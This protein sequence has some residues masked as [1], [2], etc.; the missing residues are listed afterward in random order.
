MVSCINRNLNGDTMKNFTFNPEDLAIG[1]EVNQQTTFSRE[2]LEVG[3]LV[4]EGGEASP[5]EDD[6]FIQRAS[7]SVAPVYQR[8]IEKSGELFDYYTQGTNPSNTKLTRKEKLNFLNLTESD[9][10]ETPDK[11]LDKLLFQRRIKDAAGQ[12]PNFVSKADAKA[13]EQLFNNPEAVKTLNNN[14][15]A[16]ASK[17]TSLSKFYD[18]QKATVNRMMIHSNIL[19]SPEYK[20]NF[21]QWALEF[22]I[23]DSAVRANTINTPATQAYD[24][25]WDQYINDQINTW[26]LIKGTISDPLGSAEGALADAANSV[27]SIGASIAGRVAGA[28]AGGLTGSVAG[29]VGAAV[30]AAK[31]GIIGGFIGSA[32]AAVD[33]YIMEEMNNYRDENGNINWDGVRADFDKLV[34][35]W[36]I[37]ATQQ[38]ITIGAIE[39]WLVPGVGGKIA[40]SLPA[41]VAK[42]IS[43][44]QSTKAGK[45]ASTVVAKG[46]EEAIGEGAG[47]TVA[48]SITD[49]QN[50]RLDKNTLKANARGGLREAVA[51][52]LVGGA[53]GGVSVIT[54]P[55]I[56][57]AADTT[58]T[59]TSKFKK[60][61]VIE[62]TKEDTFEAEYEVKTSEGVVEQTDIMESDIDNASAL[63]GLTDAEKIK[64]YDD[65]NAM[66]A[67]IELEDGNVIVVPAE[68]STVTVNGADLETLL[69]PDVQT[70][71]DTVDP[72]KKDIIQNAI[73]NGEDFELTYGEWVV[74]SSKLKDAHPTIA[75]LWKDPESGLY[76]YEAEEV[77]SDAFEAIQAHVDANLQ[78]AVDLP[79]LTPEVADIQAMP[80]QTSVVTKVYP[81]AN[82]NEVV[83]ELA[84]GTTHT[85]ELYSNT[86]AVEV[87]A[88]MDDLTKQFKNALSRSGRTSQEV[89]AAS[90]E[91][92][93]IITRV[94]IKR[95]AALN[96]PLSDLKRSI[97]F[98]S[99]ASSSSAYIS[100]DFN[101]PDTLTYGVGRSAQRVSTVIHEFAHAI[102]NFMIIDAPKLQYALLNGTLSKEGQE[103]LDTIN[104]TSRLLGISDISA[105][106]DHSRM[107]LIDPATGKPTRTNQAGRPLTKFTYLHEKLANTMEVFLKKGELDTENM[108]VDVAKTL[109]YWRDLIPE[110]IVNLLES[111]SKEK[112]WTYSAE[113]HQAIDP[114]AE[115]AEVFHGMYAVNQAIETQAVPLFNFRMF[116]IEL[117][118]SKG[119]EL[120]SKIIETKHKA[121]ASVYAKLYAKS[122]NARSKI[123]TPEVLAEMNR[124][125]YSFFS[126][127]E[128]GNFLSDL[129][130]LKSRIPE[131]INP[132]LSAIQKFLNDRSGSKVE[133]NRES[134]LE[135]LELAV[136][137]YPELIAGDLSFE[138]IMTN[139]ITTFNEA[140]EGIREAKLKELGYLDNESIK[141]AVESSLAKVI[142]EILDNQMAEFV[143]TYPA[144][145]KQLFSAYMRNG[146]VSSRKLSKQIDEATY[147]TFLQR[148]V[149]DVAKAGRGGTLSPKIAGYLAD[150]DRIAK[151]Q[152]V[153]LFNQGRFIEALNSVYD[154]QLKSAELRHISREVPKLVGLLRAIDQYP[155]IEYQRATQGE[156]HPEILERLRVVMDAVMNDKPLPATPIVN[157]AFPDIDAY[158]HVRTMQMLDAL[159]GYSLGTVGATIA[160]GEYARD[161]MKISRA[162]M[163]MENAI[164]EGRKADILNNAR[165]DIL[166][167][168][169]VVDFTSRFSANL[170]TINEYM[171]AYFPSQGAY[172]DSAVY[173]DI[174]YPII[175]GE[176]QMKTRFEEMGR[177]QYKYSKKSLKRKLEPMTL[178]NSGI[179]ISNREDLISV[180]ALMGS[181][182]GFETLLRTHKAYDI[183]PLTNTAVLRVDGLKDDIKELYKTGV[184]D[185]SDVEFVNKLWA[186]FD[187]LFDE[188]APLYREV[189]GIKVGKIEPMPFKLGDLEL[190]GGYFPFSSEE[191][192]ASLVD[193][194]DQGRGFNDIYGFK[195]FRRIKERGAYRREPLKLGLSVVPSY[196]QAS[197]REIYLKEHIELLKDLVWRD[198]QVKEHIDRTRPGAYGPMENGRPT[199]VLDDWIYEVE[200]QLRSDRDPRVKGI[201][202]YLHKNAVKV[203]YAYNFVGTP[204]SNI[205]GGLPAA[206][207]LM[208]EGATIPIIG[209][210]WRLL[211]NIMMAPVKIPSLMR[212]SEKSAVIRANKSELI[213]WLSDKDSAELFSPVTIA[214]KFEE[215]VAFYGIR[216]SQDILERLVWLSQYEHHLS[217]GDSE[218]DAI[219]KA[220]SLV[221]QAFGSYRNTDRSISQKSGF[222]GVFTDMATKHVIQF[223][224]QQNIE[225]KRDGPLWRRLYMTAW[226]HLMFMTSIYLTTH[227]LGKALTDARPGETEEEEDERLMSYMVKDYVSALMGPYGKIATSIV[228][229]SDG[230]SVTLSPVENVL[231]RGKNAI[232]TAYLTNQTGYE[233]SGTDWQDAFDALT[234][235]TGFSIFTGISRADAAMDYLILSEE[236]RTAQRRQRDFAR[237]Y[238]GRQL[239]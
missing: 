128:G 49:F 96:I 162:A 1:D 73:V 63:T 16:R 199:G 203:M 124:E 98:K 77:L 210:R 14:A 126:N 42:A 142:P 163:K 112:G 146:K 40:K 99:D 217:V 152:T 180:L 122:V 189:F 97:K 195:T 165:A 206:L 153:P 36:R 38:G 211:N 54:S 175:R 101:K 148:K 25:R 237:R 48:K 239:K 81:T 144:E 137:E 18:S 232:R 33:G 58:Q 229:T 2:E 135:E 141:E 129:N 59:F 23:L 177:E 108:N 120:L 9:V 214:K 88:L 185:K 131:S 69:G 171:S 37:E 30:G 121:I 192:F 41:P 170:H 156:T 12:Y 71:L 157:L 233:M 238:Y 227:V 201:L 60:K 44:V 35:K 28:A 205:L 64:I 143:A 191:D 80:K 105:V 74:S 45:V 75:T 221:L 65:A 130:L 234:L 93:P 187:K 132:Q 67:E 4:T 202:K 223:A 78:I 123:N 8:A 190:N 220:D 47:G 197:L 29:P 62:F 15:M 150:I 5:T 85:I 66:D 167:S 107:A 186:D 198:P 134:T 159:E 212:V 46:T 79:P 92:I 53:S 20:N 218:A 55:A 24:E 82:I 182:S 115:V 111:V 160:L 166:R 32:V 184:I 21:E 116:P 178:P 26:D 11:D 19:Y 193:N 235:F 140:K 31:G 13:L 76:G 50:G 100:I 6:D 176:A 222:L 226:V 39:G 200:G 34:A 43:R 216:A 196:I 164:R 183:D 207:G 27:S 168:N 209:G 103:Y 169:K 104:A 225:L 86:S 113:Y 215:I 91:G 181:K 188:V 7:K 51:G 179:E 89:I 72:A 87:Q 231:T 173:K 154:A 204:L 125:L 90:L 84:D 70:L 57:V 114:T 161:M 102:L 10:A 155:S 219:R 109:M 133:Y 174:I 213:Q 56:D 118:G 127:T 224:R 138:Q 149:T 236:E 230:R 95:A 194:F 17:A 22:Q 208:G 83:M 106:K 119:P 158:V 117:L 94:L 147:E 110:D 228:D 52:G 68:P 139:I 136:L 145:A 3:R 61:P 151:N 172:Y